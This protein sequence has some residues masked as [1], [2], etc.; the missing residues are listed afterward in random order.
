MRAGFIALA[1]VVTGASGPAWGVVVTFEPLVTNTQYGQNFGS[2]PGDLIL[3]EGGV[4]VRLANFKQTNG[5]TSFSLARVQASSIYHPTKNMSEN[6]I[7]LE[8]DFTGL[9]FAVNQVTFKFANQGGIDNM[10]IN[11]SALYV[12]TLA[13]APATINGVGVSIV[14]NA[15]QV[16]GTVTLTGVIQK[17]V[18]GGQEFSIDTITATPAPGGLVTALLGAGLLAGRRRVRPE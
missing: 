18:V 13:T 5:N 1:A 9:G 8:F 6:N 12:G 7:N 14:P 11:G 15:G 10:G 3:T 4:A 17:L 2:S 16:A